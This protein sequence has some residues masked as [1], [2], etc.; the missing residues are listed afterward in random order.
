MVFKLPTEPQRPVFNGIPSDFN[1]LVFSRSKVGKSTFASQW[2]DAL[3]LEC[4]GKAKDFLSGY[5]APV[6]SL[7]E[8]NEALNAFEKSEKYKCIVIDTL[9]AVSEWVE[10]QICRDFK[11]E[12]IMQPVKGAQNGVQ[13]TE[14]KSR[15]RALVKR[16]IS[17]KNKQVILL[18]HTR[19]PE[20]DQS[21]NVLSPSTINLYG[22]TASG[23][24]AMMDNIGYLFAHKEGTETK[25]YL[26]FRA[27]AMTEIG[28]RHPAI[29]DRII[30]VPKTGAYEAFERLFYSQQGVTK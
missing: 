6:T 24:C 1:L 11:I 26:T 23:I 8:L 14:Y 9:D 12:T 10:E 27:D 4:E 19:K 29:S 20:L 7:S 28:S 17:M 15:I 5:I 21:G 22:Q 30:I 2:K 16:L 18:A 25:R 13:W 3:V